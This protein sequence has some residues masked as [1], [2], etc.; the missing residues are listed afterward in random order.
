MSNSPRFYF[1][2]NASIGPCLRKPLE[3]RWSRAHLSEDLELAGIAGALVYHRQAV[4]YDPMLG[5]LKLIE[6]LEGYRDRLFPCWVALPATS[7]DFPS[8]PEFMRLLKQHD[9][10]AVRIDAAAFAMPIKERLW[11][12]LRDALREAGTLCVFNAGPWIPDW[13]LPALEIFKDNNVLLADI[14][15]FGTW[16]K[17]VALMDE[18]PNVHIEF[19]AFQA[20]RAIE[21]FSD[22]FGAERCLFGTA[23]PEKAPGAACGFLDYTLLPEDQAELVAG[24]NLK[25]LLGGQGPV[26][27]TV[28]SE[29]QDSLTAAARAGE[30]LPCPALDAHCHILHDGGV[31]AG[32]VE[33]FWRGDAD[34]MI[35][36]T[37]RAGIDRTAIMSWAGPLAADTDTGNAIVESAVRRYPDEFIGLATIN[38]EYD[39]PEKIEA[40]IQKYHLELGYPGLKTYTNCQ[41][42]DYDD[43][44]FARW[45]QFANDHDLYAVID[46]KGGMAGERAVR[47]LAERYPRLGIHLDHCGQS[48]AYAKWAAALM[49]EYPNIWAQLNYT[50]VTNGVIEWLAAEVGADRMLFGTD[51]PMR[52]PRPQV[53]WLVFTRLPEADK[54]KIFGGNFAAILQRA[55]IGLGRHVQATA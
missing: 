6:E 43:P 46:P 37:R 10:R 55:E 49:K 18:F 52:D 22:R 34:G 21:Y 44:L 40:I 5:N 47:N 17:L 3:A 15:W 24:Q 51:A 16:R 7:G 1:D 13:T 27:A 2:C 12:E 8:V 25:R 9:V 23:L 41:A 39:D 48:W 28:A 19:S 31:S 38:P 54:R 4:L 11:A 45:Y 33:I 53:G 42:I 20:N 26:P 14:H 32:V 36:L 50:A 35:E 30:P 29:W